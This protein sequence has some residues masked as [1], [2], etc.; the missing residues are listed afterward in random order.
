MTD[1]KAGKPTGKLGPADALASTSPFDEFVRDHGTIQRK[2]IFGHF[3]HTLGRRIIGGEFAPGVTLPNEP[4][5]AAH[6]NVSRT[7]IREAM[8]CLAGKGLVEIKTR[9]GTRVKPVSSWHHTD[10]DVMVWYYETG[11]SVEFMRSIKDLRRALEPAAAARA[12]SRG[13][14]EEIASIGEAYER[15]VSTIGDVNQNADADLD[16]HTRIF[17]ATHNPIFAQLIDVISVGIYAN[18]T[19]TPRPGAIVGQRRSLPFHKDLLD[20]IVS[21]DPDAA[22]KASNRLLDSWKIRGYDF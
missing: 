9:I 2:G 8:K 6:Y 17:T 12:T 3:V 18:R 19:I 4:E 13:S 5:L 7:I 1:D 11:P 16:F 22:A 21:R 10:T 15:M 20:A 14:D